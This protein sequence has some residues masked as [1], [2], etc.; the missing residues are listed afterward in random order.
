MNELDAILT[1][2]RAEP[3]RT[4]NAVLATVVHVKGSAYRRPGAR[5]LILADG[6]RVGTVSGGC[7]EN[8]VSRKAWWLTE[9]GHSVVRAYDTSSDDDVVWEFG[10]G[11]NGV[12][13]VLFERLECRETQEMLNFLHN[14]RTARRGGVMATVVAASPGCPSCVGDRLLVESPGLCVGALAR[15]PLE[16]E[17]RPHIST[18]FLQQRSCLAHLPGCDVFVEWVGPPIPLIVFGA[19]HDAIPLVRF[20]KELGWHVTVADGR[21]AYATVARFP[22]ADHV[23]LF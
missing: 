14:S 12:I 15:S 19:G 22:E 2:W 17:I 1:H 18:C 4:L 6:T 21:R 7:L 3:E 9:G 13:H 16:S 20:A 5:M 23:A 11:C 8:D 10:L